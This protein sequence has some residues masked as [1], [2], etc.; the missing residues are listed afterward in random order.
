METPLLWIG[1]LLLAG[2]GSEFLAERLGLP[3]V[4]LFI[5]TGAILGTLDFL[6]DG[7]LEQTEI[8]VELALAIIG[9]LIG[10]SLEW[11]R[12]RKLGNLVFRVL[13][14]EFYAATIMV[15]ISTFLIAWQV[16]A[17]PWNVALALALVLGS[18]AAATAPAATLAVV[19]EQRA[20]GP[21]TTIV[22]SIVAADDGLALITFSIAT[23][24]AGM[25]LGYEGTLFTSILEALR[26]VGLSVLLGLLGALVLRLV[27][28][29]IQQRE[30]M[31]LPTFTVILL[32]SGLA[33]YLEAGGLLACMV[34]GMALV[35]TYRHFD[36]LY[37]VISD[38]FE[39][40]IFTLFFILSG[41]HIQWEILGGVWLLATGYF[42]ARM[43]GKASGAYLAARYSHADPVI[44]K[45]TGLSL[46]PQAGVAL[47]LAL[48]ART[49]LNFPGNVAEILLSVVIATT[50]VS[51][52][53]GPF[54]TRKALILAGE[55]HS[56][57]SSPISAREP[58]DHER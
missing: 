24:G 11:S 9:F 35:N 57:R 56:M 50:T 12:L 4:S 41:M 34:L 19:H 5:L 31:L 42:V 23:A 49:G 18:I 55:S 26:E 21:L 52:L 17:L 39:S 14:S 7:F 48:Q 22:L 2:F 51:E 54:F 58:V 6:P 33:A 46:M 45:Y 15:A 10:G 16:S 43:M 28:R 1:I 20:R 40:I 44:R 29:R 25:L 32:C 30:T 38:S 27:L 36:S 47:G 53:L 8:I 13:F 37:S 3:G